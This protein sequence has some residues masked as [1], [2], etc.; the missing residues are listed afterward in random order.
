VRAVGPGERPSWGE[1]SGLT[2]VEL[3]VAFGILAVMLSAVAA[4][5]ITSARATHDNERRV[6]SSA[7]M[8]RLH[9]ELQS[10]PWHDAALYTGELDEL[11][12][13]A[14]PDDAGVPLHDLDLDGE[15]FEGRPLVLLEGPASCPEGAPNCQP[16]RDHVPRASTT[17][18]VDSADPSRGEYEIYQLVTWDDEALG[19]KHFTTIVRWTVLNRTLEE[20]FDSQRAATPAEAGD[21]QRPRVI[22]FEVGPSPMALHTSETGPVDTTTG[23]LHVVVR[24]SAGVESATLRYYTLPAGWAAGDPT[25]DDLVLVSEDMERNVTDPE[26]GALGLGWRFTIPAGSDR[27]PVGA[28]SFRVSGVLGAETFGGATSA[29]FYG[30]TPVAP[31]ADP[32]DTSD[33]GDT[34]PEDPGGGDTEPPAQ[35]VSLVNPT[36]NRTTVCLD[37]NDRFLK[38]VTIQVQVTGMTPDDYSVSMSYTANGEHRV[39][40]MQPVVDVAAI[41]PA[42]TTFAR[43]FQEKAEHRFR[44]GDRTRF[45]ILASRS[46]DGMKAGPLQTAELQVSKPNNPDAAGQGCG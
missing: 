37:A 31:V 27:F 28:R 39:E 19:I 24:F 36:L 41:S 33:P 44:N 20:R 13:L 38:T 14:E 4:S 29:E 9:E 26:N 5:L 3:M 7:M 46:S 15:T 42:G 11:E 45:T 22:Q 12:P 30:G 8:N 17:A 43:T 25:P 1:Q 40:S 6:Q 23:D 16:R 2:L 18:P 21:P 34:I 35:P 32:E 10:I